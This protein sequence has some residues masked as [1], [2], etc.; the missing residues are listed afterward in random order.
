[1]RRVVILHPYKLLVTLPLASLVLLLSTPFASC[2]KTAPLAVSS[3]TTMRSLARFTPS[4]AGIA[5]NRILSDGRAR[6][7]FVGAASSRLHGIWSDNEGS[8]PE[9]AQTKNPIIANPSAFLP[10]Y[11]KGCCSNIYQ[12]NQHHHRSFHTSST[13][14]MMAKRK[15]NGGKSKKA[16]SLQHGGPGSVGGKKKKISS[17]VA[18]S[19]DEDDVLDSSESG[20]D[21]ALDLELLHEQYD[22]EESG[23]GDDDD[24]DDWGDGNELQSDSPFAND[25]HAPV[26]P[27]EC[28]QALLLQGEWEEMLNA[29]KD[30]WR[31]KQSIIEAKRRKAPL[32]DDGN[33]EENKMEDGGDKNGGSGNKEVF[34]NEEGITRRPR[35]FIDGTLGGG[36]HSQAI[37]EQLSAGDILISC[38]VDPEALAT[39]SKRLVEYLGTSDYILDYP[40]GYEK[41]MGQWEEGKPMFIPV[42]SNFRNLLSV[43][44][45]VRHPV[46]G[47]LLFGDRRK[48]QHHRENGINDGEDIVEFPYGANGMLLDLGVSSHQIDTGERGFAFM[49][50]G[51]LDMRMSGSSNNSAS[52]SYSASTLTAADICNE[53][54]E[55]SIV[56]ILRTYGDEPRAKRIASAIVASRPL[57]TTTD[58]VHAINSVTPTFARQR[59]A[60]LIATCARVFQAL[61]IVVNEEDGALKEVLEEV[62]PAI[63][64]RSGSRH[65]SSKR[66]Q[67]LENIHDGILAVLSY[68]SME[69]KMAKR[70]IRDGK[71]DLFGSRRGGSG[72]LERDLYGNIIADDND[73]YI[74]EESSLTPFEPLCKPRKATDEEIAVN[75]RA[76]SATLRVA[77]R[78]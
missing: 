46:T 3:L 33:E 30:R 14:L 22:L 75:S 73:S 1:M 66:Q 18:V 76:R 70:V 21:Q 40:V 77:I 37:L 31:K 35:V 48:R 51:P 65:R 38:D 5:Q 45:K 44:A 53:F 60:G 59:R 9:S 6:A 8:S 58:L 64:C 54:D 26:M 74:G 15:K 63:L 42:Q 47:N 10:N 19:D 4:A 7:A 69:D 27:T 32:H 34:Q 68:H 16:K 23:N 78:I 39:A 72:V 17:I 49:K 56:S 2:R 67:D 20:A 13:L 71:V 55:G 11:S 52:L 41:V 61:R 57:Y 25:Y 36:G 24:D 28:I 29:K 50:D 43:L 62:A 12:F